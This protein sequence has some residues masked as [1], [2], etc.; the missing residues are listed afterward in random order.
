[1]NSR[2]LVALAT[3]LLLLL[4]LGGLLQRQG[5]ERLQALPTLLI[6]SGLLV[7]SAEGYR[8]RRHRLLRALRDPSELP[9]P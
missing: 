6:G 4:A 5:V 1:V 9:P 3:P 7:A 2:L 8:R